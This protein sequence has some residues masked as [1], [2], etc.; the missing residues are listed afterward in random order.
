MPE[1]GMERTGERGER[2][3]AKEQW[4][5]PQQASCSTLCGKRSCQ[6][7]HV[8]NLEEIMHFMISGHVGQL[9]VINVQLQEQKSVILKHYVAK[10]R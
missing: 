7:S 9:A 2:R 5:N 1:V 8:G 3:K 6:K 10:K 4:C